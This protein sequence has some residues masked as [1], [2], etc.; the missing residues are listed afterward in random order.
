MAQRPGNL[1]AA[2]TSFIGRDEDLARIEA[3]LGTGRLVTVLGPGGAGKTRL[4]LE[5]AG[6]LR[7]RYPGGTWLVDLAPVTEPAEVAAAVVFLASPQASAITGQTYNICGGQT[8][9]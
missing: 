6:R 5:A 4:A 3:L 8:M 7:G 2:L 1:P 9:D